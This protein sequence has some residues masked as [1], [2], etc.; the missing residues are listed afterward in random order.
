MSDLPPS[1]PPSPSEGTYVR[2][3]PEH[4]VVRDSTDNPV[5][6]Q[7]ALD[8]ALLPIHKW[9]WTATGV[10]LLNIAPTVAKYLPQQP[11]PTPVGLLEQLLR[12]L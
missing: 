9:L 3:I 11:P 2:E 4:P 10:G 1:S 7:S 12:H 5:V 6:R 8:K